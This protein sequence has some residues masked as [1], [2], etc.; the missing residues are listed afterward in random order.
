MREEA[1][2]RE[3]WAEQAGSGSPGWEAGWGNGESPAPQADTC[4]ALSAPSLPP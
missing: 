4:T 1:T 2:S 3:V